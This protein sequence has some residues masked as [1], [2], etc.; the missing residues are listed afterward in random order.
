MSELK[1]LGIFLP[2]PFMARQ[3]A[4]MEMKFD[5]PDYSSATGTSTEKKA[6]LAAAK[7]L[8][9]DAKNNYD[10][11]RAASES[12]NNAFNA[13]AF[14]I[15]QASE[16]QFEKQREATLL[17]LRDH[18]MSEARLAVWLQILPSLGE[19]F[20][21]IE[22]TVDFGL[23]AAL[24]AA[25]ELAV[26][27]DRDGERQ[28]LQLQF[29]Q[30]TL[31]VE[32]KGDPIQFHRYVLLAGRKLALLNNEAVR[33][34][35]MKAVFIKGLPDDIFLGFK[36]GLHNNPASCKTF[37]DV[38]QILKVFAGSDSAKPKINDLIKLRA[39][40]YNKSGPAGVFVARAV[41]KA[42]AAQ[43]PTTRAVCFDFSKGRC[44]RGA[45]CKFLHSTAPT[46][47]AVTCTHCLKT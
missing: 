16:L 4:P 22:E 23:P 3:L 21:K 44:T 13:D 7:A 11:Q 26:F 45:D 1:L 17:V 32:G 42:P 29:W 38:F 8:Y 35:D 14:K 25:I 46:P 18:H 12:Q 34:A 40:Q 39:R 24:V 20:Y 41:P 6:L 19:S 9:D 37:D 15:H 30:A 27:R 47:A 31:E 43:S 5:I 28:Q 33:D 10:A 36:T 2:P